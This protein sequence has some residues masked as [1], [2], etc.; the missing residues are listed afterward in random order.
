MARYRIDRDLLRGIK[1]NGVYQGFQDAELRGFGLKITPTG[2]IT[3]TYR[4]TR[5][6]GSQG[7]K[8]IGRYPDLN[9]GEARE[10]ARKESSLL[11]KKGDTLTQMAERKRQR[12]ESQR[13]VGVPTLATFLNERYDLYL[14][15]HTKGGSAITQLIRR[16][17]GEFLDKPLDEITTWQLEKWRSERKAEGLKPSTLNNKL[18]ALRGA[19]SRAME[20]EV[21]ATH[22]MTKI[23]ALK[24]PS[25]IV[26]FLSDDEDARLHA[27]LIKRETEIREA[28][29][30]ANEHRR[31]RHHKQMADLNSLAFTDYL[32]PAVLVSLNTGVRR[33]ELL[34]LRWSD[35]DLD[36]AILTV[37]DEHAKSSKRRH[38]PLNTEALTTLKA[39]KKQ[40]HSEFVFAG[41]TGVPINEIKTAWGNVLDAAKIQKFRWHDLRHTFASRLVQRGV[42]LNVV[43]ELLGHASLT[44]TLRYSH[45]APEHRAAAVATLDRPNHK[46]QKMT[47]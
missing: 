16:S 31:V 32:R 37:R 6:D 44:M 19:F 22:P 4:W 13:A 30:R 26:R 14:Q 10:L 47:D 29:D 12:T 18:T 43:R 27:T 15:A 8:T 21:I 5:P 7:R 2:S 9:P 25:G 28:R 33:G 34:T 41:E 24:E 17:F 1:A 20:W 36:R 40:A 39:W 46:H 42:D 23:K 3:Y 11:E 38:I 35:V 45:L